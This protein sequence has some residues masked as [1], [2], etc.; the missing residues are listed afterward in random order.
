MFEESGLSLGDVNVRQ[1]SFAQ[2]H[3]SDNESGELTSNNSNTDQDDESMSESR[4]IITN[5]LLDIYA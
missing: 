2:Q 5:S 4:A 1:E 3:N